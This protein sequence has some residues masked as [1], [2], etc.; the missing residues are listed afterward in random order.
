MRHS[1]LYRYPLSLLPGLLPIYTEILRRL[2]ADG[3][4]WVQ[5]DEP[6]LVLDLDETT[7]KALHDAYST[8][9]IFLQA[10]VRDWGNGFCEETDDLGKI[11]A[12]FAERAFSLPIVKPAVHF[13]TYKLVFFVS[14]FMTA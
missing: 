10:K 7:K 1:I 8:F 11:K 3:A 6:C 9:A 12:M 5:I 2:E 13:L 14:K 4:D